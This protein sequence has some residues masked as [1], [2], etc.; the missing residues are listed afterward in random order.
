VSLC[1]GVG[2][3][4]CNVR[5]QLLRGERG[6]MDVLIGTKAIEIPYKHCLLRNEDYYESRHDCI[7]IRRQAKYKE[8]H[9][10]LERADD[11]V[12]YHWWLEV[13]E[14]GA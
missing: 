14:S 7:V 12:L 6:V 8:Y 11:V 4:N 10:E 3:D 5:E 1:S 9:D 2:P 13:Y